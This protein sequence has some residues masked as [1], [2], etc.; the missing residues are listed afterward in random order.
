M[1]VVLQ[2][3]LKVMLL[4]LLKF[5]K[6]FLQKKTCGQTPAVETIIKNFKHIK[7]YFEA[8]K[9]TAGV[10]QIE[11]HKAIIK[12]MVGNLPNTFSTESNCI[13]SIT[14]FKNFTTEYKKAQ[15]TLEKSF[16]DGSSQK[17]YENLNLFVNFETVHTIQ[18]G[19]EDSHPNKL[20]EKYS[21]FLTQQNTLKKI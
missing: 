3:R 17:L 9:T 15:D 5:L 1:I 13:V 7:N 16:E 20:D 21:N 18:D 14:N 19:I 8:D 11:R 6:K 4:R 12:G 10:E 2:R